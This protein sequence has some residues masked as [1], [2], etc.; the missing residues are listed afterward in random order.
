MCL[1]IVL[2]VMTMNRDDD[3][4]DDNGADEIAVL[5]CQLPEARDN[6]ACVLLVDPCFD[7]VV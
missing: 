1:V 3:D 4:D 5:A 2:V 7:F 6:E